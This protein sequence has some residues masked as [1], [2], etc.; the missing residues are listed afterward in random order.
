MF[1]F[2]SFEATRMLVDDHIAE[3]HRTSPTRH[4]TAKGRR[5]RGR[6]DPDTRTAR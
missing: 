1:P 5:R 2:T 3:L 6:A 4:R